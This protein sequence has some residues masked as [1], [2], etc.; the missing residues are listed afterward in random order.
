MGFERMLARSINY[1]VIRLSNIKRNYI[2]TFINYKR[3][4][5]T[6]TNIM[7]DKIKMQETM[8]KLMTPLR[9]LHA[10]CPIIGETKADLLDRTLILLHPGN[11]FLESNIKIK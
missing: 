8:Q 2:P 1:P 7:N 3:R 11:T 9:K 6:P 5:L 10:K 4:N